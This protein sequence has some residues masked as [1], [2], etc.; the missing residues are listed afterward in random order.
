MSA[1]LM[2]EYATSI[3]TSSSPGARGSIS[4]VVSVEAGPYLAITTSRCMAAPRRSAAMVS[5]RGGARRDRRCE[6]AS[7]SPA[8]RQ[9]RDEAAYARAVELGERVV[10]QPRVERVLVGDQ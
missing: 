4:R 6:R 1:K 7:V 5:E 8:S 9:V 10:D 2:P 3:A